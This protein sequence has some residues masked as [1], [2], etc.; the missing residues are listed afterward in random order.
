M[1]VRSGPPDVRIRG[2][3][4]QDTCPAAAPRAASHARPAASGGFVT[5][6]TLILASVSAVALVLMS[7]CHSTPAAAAGSNAFA[8]TASDKAVE[9]RLRASDAMPALQPFDEGFGA[10]PAVAD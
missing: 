8:A 10:A 7:G 1:L 2:S 3:I 9:A 6:G 4:M 5:V